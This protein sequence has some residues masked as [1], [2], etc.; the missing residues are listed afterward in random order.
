MPVLDTIADI[1]KTG[2]SAYVDSQRGS[3]VATVQPIPN[4]QDGP[5]GSSQSTSYADALKNPLVI[6]GAILVTVV[7]LALVFK[8]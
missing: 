5:A 8:K 1:F 7:V 2:A 6:G 3:A 4:T